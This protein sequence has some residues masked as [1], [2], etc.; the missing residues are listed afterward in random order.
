LDEKCNP[1]VRITFDE[2]E[3]LGYSCESTEGRGF[4]EDQLIGLPLGMAS[5]ALFSKYTSN[6]VNK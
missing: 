6:E 4:V 3:D 2:D 5:V 1:R